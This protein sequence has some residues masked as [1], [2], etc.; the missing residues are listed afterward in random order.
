MQGIP[1]GFALTAVAN[2]LAGEGLS[3]QS[4]GT[5]VAIVGTPWIIKFI[6]GPLIDRYQYSIIGHRKHWVVFTQLLAFAVSLNLLSINDPVNQLALMSALF[7][8][9]SI[10]ASIQDA[11]VDAIAISIVP[12]SQRGR[13][14]AFMKGGYLSGIAIGAAGL[15]TI[16]HFYGFFYAAAAQSAMLLL[17]TLL[18]FCIKLD[19]T[20][21]ILLSFKSA[22]NAKSVL[23][24]KENPNLKWLFVE[25]YQAIT[26]EKNLKI[27][28][29]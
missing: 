16:L 29:V 3:S 26:T 19:H 1:S 4:V 12:E 27:F 13:V 2:Y 20:D 25:L 6:W 8:L 17:M 7:F 18:T 15:S 23:A 10:F 24:K 28:A 22:G 11:S 14:N 5:F 21:K 9:H